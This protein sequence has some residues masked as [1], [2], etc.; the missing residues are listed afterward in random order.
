MRMVA[1]C[2]EMALAI[3]SDWDMVGNI[4]KHRYG[5]LKFLN[6]DVEGKILKN[7]Y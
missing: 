1:R 7:I 4:P 6:H 2:L 5:K 3:F